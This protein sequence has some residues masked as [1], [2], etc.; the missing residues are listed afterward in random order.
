MSFYAGTLVEVNLLY[1]TVIHAN[2]N[3]PR[4]TNDKKTQETTMSIL[5]FASSTPFS[6]GTKLELQLLERDGYSLATDAVE[7]SDRFAPRNSPNQIKPHIALGMVE[8]KS[9]VHTRADHLMEDLKDLRNTLVKEAQCMHIDVAGG[10]AHP[11]Q[12]LNDQS[13]SSPQH[14]Q[15]AHEKY[16]Y[17][18]KTCTV[19]GQHIHIGVANGDDALYLTHGFSRFV[20]HFIALSAASPFYKGRDTSFDSTRSNVVHTFPLSGTIP[21]VTR[22]HEFESCYHELQQIGI[23]RDMHDFYWDIRPKPEYG[24][25][26]VRVCDTPLTLGHAALLACFVQLLARWLLAERPFVIDDNFYA[27]YQTNRFEASRRGLNGE[28]AIPGNDSTAPPSKRS[29]FSSVVDCLNNLKRYAANDAD[30]LFL[31]RLR[32]IAHQKLNDA[33]RLRHAF[34]QHGSLHGVMQLSARL[35]MTHT[36]SPSF[37]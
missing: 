15:D 1:Q 8:I 17:L 32:Y 36:A 35:W 23:I 5:P 26:E 18:A 21:L 29:I 11:F 22:W 24:T 7:L 20:P 14:F 6:V 16:D 34:K 37:Q 19:F 10:G 2:T 9:G 3:F 13:M 27:L 25:V 30:L 12:C 33:C 31:R 28:I 4:D